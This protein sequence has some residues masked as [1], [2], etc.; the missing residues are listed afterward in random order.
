[1]A[2]YKL[3]RFAI[4]SDARLDAEREM[5][6]FASYV[7]GELP[8]SSWTA[9]RDPAEPAHFISLT[10]AE[11]VVADELHRSSPGYQAFVAAITPLLDGTIEETGLELVT[12]SDLARRHKPG[13]RPGGRR[14]PR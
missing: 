3:A 7:R 12:S 4:R 9:Y 11:H 13:A 14:R 1:M 5:Y 6:A 2:V 8:D 10:R